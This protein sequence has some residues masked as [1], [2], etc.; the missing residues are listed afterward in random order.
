[1]LIRP[2]PLIPRVENY[3]WG[4]L[5]SNSYLARYLKNL[6]EGV[7]HAELWIGAHDKNPSTIKGSGKSLAELIETHPIELLGA[8]VARTYA[9]TLPFLLKILSIGKPLSI[10][11]HP[12]KL[13]AKVL[14]D[15]DPALYPDCNHKPELAVALTRTELLH[16]FRS[17]E[18]VRELL[19]DVVELREL[20][21]GLDLLS[22][23]L[24]RN[25]FCQLLKLPSGLVESKAVEL[26]KRLSRK[27]DR[28]FEEQWIL[29]LQSDYPRG[30]I[31]VFCFFLLNYLV[32]DIG[33]AI[34]TAPNECHAYLSGDVLEC[35]ANSDNVVRCGLTQ[36]VR[37]SA[38]LNLMLNNLSPSTSV[39]CEIATTGGR[40]SYLVPTEEFA[41][42]V[43]QGTDLIIPM[44]S[45]AAIISMALEGRGVIRWSEGGNDCLP[46]AAGD[47]FFIP[48]S[49]THVVFDIE[50]GQVA[51]CSCH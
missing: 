31:G 4:K 25:I 23:Q 43:F 49:L 8:E 34:Y 6:A 36:K 13:L 21:N 47:S 9:N 26:Y 16:G 19:K 29:N 44:R 39:K 15:S 50:E 28:S 12:D 30:D 10:Q 17:G 48:A 42:D 14:H 33:D 1:M 5:G 3:P 7:P 51:I 2:L 24:A 35:M 18:Q 37:D 40:R 45:N 20:A 11:A 22:E 46:F 41:L 32:L 27:A 38:T